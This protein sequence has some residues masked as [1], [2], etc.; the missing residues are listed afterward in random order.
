MNEACNTQHH[1]GPFE[2][3]IEE[4]EM[5]PGG[6]NRQKEASNFQQNHGSV[7][8]TL[9]EEMFPSGWNNQID[10]SNTEYYT[11]PVQSALPWRRK[12]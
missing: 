7:K 11:G 5:T 3:A 12:K 2:D 6:C 10:P 4:K 1:H 8:G 9:E